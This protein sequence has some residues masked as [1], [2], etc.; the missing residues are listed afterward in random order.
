MV[1]ELTIR[2]DEVVRKLRDLANK[3]Q[4]PVE[5]VLETMLAQYHT[6]EKVT[7]EDDPK[8][9]TFAALAAS[10]KRAGLASEKPVDTSERTREIMKSEYAEYV[11][12]HTNEQSDAG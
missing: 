11:R 1:A 3:E 4:R 9:G 5:Q 10:A 2:G 12:R 8:P 6:E 7:D